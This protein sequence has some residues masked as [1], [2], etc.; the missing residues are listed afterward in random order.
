MARQYHLDVPGQGSV[1]APG[2]R[3]DSGAN[4]RRLQRRR[5][6]DRQ[7]RG[8]LVADQHARASCRRG[9][10]RYN[11]IRRS[12]VMRSTCCEVIK[13]AAVMKPIARYME[14]TGISVGQLVTTSGLDAA[15]VKAI[16]SG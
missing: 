9:R 4:A 11:F 8:E 6:L 3:R 15:V 7:K 13:S 12:D 1:G 2:E 14:D 5:F 16:V 10:R